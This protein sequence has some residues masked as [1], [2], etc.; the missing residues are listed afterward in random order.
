MFFLQI[1]SALVTYLTNLTPA[2][3]LASV[4]YVRRGQCMNRDIRVLPVMVVKATRGNVTVN[5]TCSMTFRTGLYYVTFR[6]SL[7]YVTFRRPMSGY[8]QC[9]VDDKEQ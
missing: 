3:R 6:T 8:R 9:N 4:L 5:G 1:N 2:W 7:Y